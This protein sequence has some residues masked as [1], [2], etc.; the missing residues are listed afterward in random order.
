MF[1]GCQ[2][3]TQ[4]KSREP[5]LLE[6]TDALLGENISPELKLFSN[7]ASKQRSKRACEQAILQ[8]K[9]LEINNKVWALNPDN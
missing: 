7:K 1:Y 2:P 9:Q 5:K 4:D 8:I 3:E 6:P